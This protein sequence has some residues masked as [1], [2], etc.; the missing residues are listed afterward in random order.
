MWQTLNVCCTCAHNTIFSSQDKK[1]LY[2]RFVFCCS[3]KI[4]TI[5]E[6]LIHNLNYHI[7]GPYVIIFLLHLVEP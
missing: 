3:V 2:S 1:T 4:H 5:I 6:Q 7:S